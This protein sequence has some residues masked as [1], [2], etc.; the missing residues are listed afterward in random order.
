MD[1][2]FEFKRKVSQR[3]FELLERFDKENWGESVDTEE[4]IKNNFFDKKKSA[5]I[6]RTGGKIV[7]L[8]FIH[9]RKIDFDKKKI[10]LAGIGGVVVH[11]EHRHKGIATKMLQKTLEILK[12]EKFD[13]AMLC[14]EINKLGPLYTV[15]GFVPLRKPYLF[16]DRNGKMQKDKEGMIAPVLSKDVFERILS[17]PE[18]INVGISNF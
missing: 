4:Y 9:F 17:S 13:I 2:D 16:T 6:A 3:D 1:L 8:L 10:K 12:E 11:K 5:I 18:I 15:V 14:T 7:G